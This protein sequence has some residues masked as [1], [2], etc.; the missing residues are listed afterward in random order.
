[1]NIFN[2][3]I[4]ILFFLRATICVVLLSSCSPSIRFSS[5]GS[6]INNSKYGKYN[7]KQTLEQNQN[8]NYIKFNTNTEADLENHKRTKINNNNET[9]L[10][11]EYRNHQFQFATGYTEK[12]K[13]SFYGDEFV[14]RLTSNGEIYEHSLLTAAHR[15]LPFGTLVS[16]HNLQNNKT[17]R[18]RINDRGPF[19][20]GR[21]IDLSRSAAEA[22]DMIKNGIVEI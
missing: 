12:G 1:M 4:I 18:V 15:S 3:K 22:L 6:N 2:F 10:R 19:A 20:E 13:A 5:K 8:P 21:I 7:A 16:V 9:N 11:N 14:G 17:I